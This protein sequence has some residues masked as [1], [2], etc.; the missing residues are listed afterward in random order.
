MNLLQLVLYMEIIGKKQ[1]FRKLSRD[2]KLKITPKNVTINLPLSS[3]KFILGGAPMR[4]SVILAE[5][6]TI[7]F[8]YSAG[9]HA[10][11]IPLCTLYD[12]GTRDV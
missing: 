4:N 11:I 8:A 9:V 1:L 6:A 10:V 12:V 3:T 5:F 7:S 2:K